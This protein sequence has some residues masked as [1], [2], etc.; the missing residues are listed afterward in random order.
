MKFRLL[1]I[2]TLF[3]ITLFAQEKT[4]EAKSPWS[5]KGITGLNFSQTSFTNWSEGG[6]TQW[7]VMCI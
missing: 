3:S 4:E 2:A 6:E 7:Q 5:Y 1:L